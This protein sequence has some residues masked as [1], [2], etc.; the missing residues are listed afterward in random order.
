MPDGVTLTV[1]DGASVSVPED[2]VLTIP[3][4]ASL[5]LSGQGQIVNNGT[6]VLPENNDL[7]NLQVQ[8]LLRKVTVFIQVIING[9][10]QLQ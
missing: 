9:F 10:I 8:V 1:P 4:S 7:I 3:D 5:Q 2:I 6:V